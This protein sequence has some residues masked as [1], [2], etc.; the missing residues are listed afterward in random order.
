MELGLH[1]LHSSGK[2]F[3]DEIRKA[4]SKMKRKHDRNYRDTLWLP[5]WTNKV[6]IMIGGAL[7]KLLMDCAKILEYFFY[8]F[9]W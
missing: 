5:K 6:K 4:A 8:L 1:S 2:L 7:A 3:D 9:I